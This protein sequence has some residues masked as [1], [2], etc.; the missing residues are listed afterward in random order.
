MSNELGFEVII[1]KS[2]TS[3]IWISRCPRLNLCTQGKS[4]E[5]ALEA[6]IEVIA[7]E[8]LQ[9]SDAEQVEGA[10]KIRVPLSL[11]AQ[12]ANR[13]AIKTLQGHSEGV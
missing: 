11:I 6:I 4:K 8:L 2:K 3:G 5:Q 7:F 10:S 13:P 1:H 9:Q 12:E